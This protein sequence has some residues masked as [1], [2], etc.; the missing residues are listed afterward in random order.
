MNLDKIEELYK[1]LLKVANEGDDIVSKAKKEVAWKQFIDYAKEHTGEAAAFFETIDK[2]KKE[3]EEKSKSFEKS[4]KVYMKGDIIITD[5]CYVIK[6]EL[7]HKF[8]DKWFEYKE[9]T[10]NWLKENY[11]FRNGIIADTLYG[12]WGC[13][14][15]QV[16]DIKFA[17]AALADG[18]DEPSVKISEGF[19]LMQD[20]FVY[21]ILMTVLIIIKK[22]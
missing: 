9:N 17:L 13:T 15:F 22:K 21:F 12:D 2:V 20:L 5:P 14:T 18:K 4:Q 11:G 6:D 8:C 10:I 16:A 3:A 19:V 1:E 7:W